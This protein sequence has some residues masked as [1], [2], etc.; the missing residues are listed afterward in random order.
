MIRQR[1]PIKRSCIRFKRRPRKVSWQS[2]RVKEDAAGMARLRSAAFQRSRGR[3]ECHRVENEFPE[4]FKP[5]G[6][7]S[8][9]WIDGHLHHSNPRSDVL[10]RVSFI[11]RRCHEII[12]GELQWSSMTNRGRK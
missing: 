4:G 12:T 2:G 9:N 6:G 7:L 8:V 3:C 10:E 1:K 5:C 11:R